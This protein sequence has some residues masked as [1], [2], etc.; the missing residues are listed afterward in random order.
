MPIATELRA[1]QTPGTAVVVANT[2]VA[3]MLAPAGLEFVF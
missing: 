3:A 1:A 2:A